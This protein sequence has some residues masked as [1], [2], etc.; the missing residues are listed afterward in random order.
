MTEQQL[1]ELYIQTEHGTFTP[2]YTYED[3]ILNEETEE[4]EYIGL[5]IIKTA[6][7]VYEEWLESKDKPIV[8]EK[9]LEEKVNA[10]EEQVNLILTNQVQLIQL[11]KERE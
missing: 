5:E 2:I 8:E 6:Q 3:F 11:L 9:T 7:D 4:Y 10:L 1:K